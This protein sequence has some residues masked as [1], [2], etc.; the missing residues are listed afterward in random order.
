MEEEKVSY[1]ALDE[2]SEYQA[3]NVGFK[4]GIAYERKRIAQKL[5]IDEAELLN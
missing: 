2:P 1:S 5:G 4:E 3:Y